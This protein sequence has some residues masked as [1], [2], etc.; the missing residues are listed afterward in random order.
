MTS[1]EEAPNPDRHGRRAVW[2]AYL[3]T[4]IGA[5]L[6]YKDKAEEDRSAFVRWRHQVLEIREGKNIWDRYY[7]PNPP[8]L[9][10]T[11]YP[12]MTLPPVEG[13]LCW[14]S[15]KASI[16][17]LCMMACMR[18]AKPP[19]LKFP[20]WAQAAVVLLCLRPIMGD[21]HHGNNNLII[22]G[23]IVTTLWAWRRGLDVM[24]GLALAL[25]ICY[26]VTPAL[27][28]PYFMYK[29]SWRTVGA[30]FL[31]IVLFLLVVPSLILGPTFNVQC[32]ASWYRRILSPYMENGS[33][34]PQEVNQSMVGVIYRLLLEPKAAGEHSYGTAKLDLN[35]ASLP[36]GLVSVV[37]KGLSVVLVGLL[38]VLCRTKTT[39]RKD[40]RLLGEFSLVVLTMLFVS[41]RSWKHHYVTMVLPYTYLVARTLVLPAEKRVRWILAGSLA[42]SA[43]LMACTSSEIGSLLVK[44]GHK[45]AQ[46]YGLFF[47]AGVVAYVATA[48]R[49]A[50]EARTSPL[51]PVPALT[52]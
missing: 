26:K 3:V 18:M 19:W 35:I 42:L 32:L 33:G 40:P 37:A 41:E 44:H 2:I 29:R 51:E 38:A 20:S 49:V 52:S 17:A 31:G 30:T 14:F 9:A 5:G 16:A 34:S 48:W 36:Q 12:L 25:A 15:L 24:A 6:I 21:L 7:F 1:P 22:F 46:F 43:F 47:W 27:F 28:V 39:D 13:A 11:V 23:L 50:A 8:I 45:I 4:M 10:L